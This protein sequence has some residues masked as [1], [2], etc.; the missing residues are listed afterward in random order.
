M[1]CSEGSPA[2]SSNAA[3]RRFQRLHAQLHGA[4]RRSLLTVMVV[5]MIMV[6]IVSG[7]HARM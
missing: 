4:R 1:A 2:S 5:I 3:G 6:M 7:A